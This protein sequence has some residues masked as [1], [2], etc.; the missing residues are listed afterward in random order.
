M[1]PASG[2]GAPRPTPRQLS[3]LRALAQRTGQTF[4][5]PATRSEASREIDR[6]KTAA[7]STPVERAIERHDW[8]RETAA[9]EANCDVPVRREELDG[10]G[11]SGTWRRRS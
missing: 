11:S 2:A 8:A 7:P 3:Y 4:T 6:L 1:T 10:Y 5:W 9:R